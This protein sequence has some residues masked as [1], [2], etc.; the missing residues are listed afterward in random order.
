MAKQ[1]FLNDMI[2]DNMDSSNPYAD[3]FMDSIGKGP[4]RYYSG[5]GQVYK[6]S[7]RYQRGYG[8]LGQMY[9]PPTFRHGGSG[10]GSALMSMFRFAMPLIKR[11]VRKLGTEAVDVASKIA[12]DAIQG[13]DISESAKQHASEKVSEVMKQVPEALSAMTNKSPAVA[14]AGSLSSRPLRRRRVYGSRYRPRSVG[15]RRKARYPGLN[16]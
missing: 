15:G 11:G 16:F 2:D 3:Y 4:G 5:I 9:R 14:E 12:T 10:I 1:L 6:A 7:S 13:K 8:Y